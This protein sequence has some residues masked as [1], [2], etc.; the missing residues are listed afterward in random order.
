MW[1]LT[2]CSDRL[3]APH[4]EVKV[5]ESP[6]LNCVGCGTASTR[7]DC[8]GEDCHTHETRNAERLRDKEFEC[9]LNKLRSVSPLNPIFSTQ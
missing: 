9:N 4:F 5:I 3:A 1:T 6:H 7:E 8:H 2:V